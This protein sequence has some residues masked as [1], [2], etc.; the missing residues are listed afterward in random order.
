MEID[1][2][3]NQDFME[4]AKGL[5]DNSI[6]CC[7]TDSPY[8]CTSRGT[9][10]TMSGY[11]TDRLSKKGKLFENNNCPADKWMP[12]VYRVLKDGGHFYSMINNVN[13]REHLNAL[14]SCG[15]RFIRLLVWDKVTPICGTAYMSKTEFITFSYKGSFH[16]VNDCGI[17]DI[18]PIRNIKPKDKKGKV[19]HPSAKPIKLMQLLVNQS[20]NRGDVV[21]DPFGGI[22]TTAI[23]CIRSDRHYICCEIDPQYYNIGVKRIKEEENYKQA[24][25]FG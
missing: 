16:A 15:F 6:D 12:E 3:Y 17:S 11:W 14:Q 20:T 21:F 22:M 1:K 9:S 8:L 25:L 2:I 4:M 5:K 13:L 18:I 10:G 19:L 24:D 7:I 23:A